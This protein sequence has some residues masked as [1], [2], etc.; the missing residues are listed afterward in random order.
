VNQKRVRR[1]Y[2]LEGL[3]LWMR[4]RC[5]KHIALHRGPAAVPTGPTER[6]S[7]DFVYDALAD[8]RQFRVL[9]VVDQWSRQSPV[10]FSGGRSMGMQEDACRA[11]PGAKPRGP[12]GSQ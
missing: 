2:R 7:M 6:W 5:R 4:V 3:Q 12:P 9:T 10:H 1:L 11:M 8:G